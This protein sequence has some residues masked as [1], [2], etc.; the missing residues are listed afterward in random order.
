MLFFL[1]I[2]STLLNISIAQETP[3]EKEHCF[4]ASYAHGNSYSV[5]KNIIKNVSQVSPFRREDFAINPDKELAQCFKY[6]VPK[7]ISEGLERR[8]TEM[9]VLYR[10]HEIHPSDKMLKYRVEIKLGSGASLPPTKQVWEVFPHYTYIYNPAEEKPLTLKLARHFYPE[11]SP[12]PLSEP[13]TT[14]REDHT[15]NRNIL[16][17]TIQI[18]ARCLHPRLIEYQLT[19]SN[20]EKLTIQRETNTHIWIETIIRKLFKENYMPDDLREMYG[21]SIYPLEQYNPNLKKLFEHPYVAG[22]ACLPPIEQI[23][24]PSEEGQK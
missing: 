1:L 3:I 23:K 17:D 9:R 7:L 16:N 2:S 18:K 11:T 10:D 5:V 24:S 8:I 22:T 4:Y 12:R 6:K 14:Y 20:G 13:M 15:K 21:Y 19:H